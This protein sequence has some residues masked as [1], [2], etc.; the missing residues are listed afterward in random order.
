MKFFELLFAGLSAAAVVVLIYLVVG[1]LYA[2]PVMWI[3]NWMMPELFGMPLLNF[4][5]SFWGVFMCSILFKGG[6]S[7]KTNS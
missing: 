5:Q 2:F 3:W 7:Y 1:S 4:W 6:N